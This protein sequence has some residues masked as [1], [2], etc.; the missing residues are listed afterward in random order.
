MK[1]H[2]RTRL[3]ARLRH[4]QPDPPDILK[5]KSMQCAILGLL[6]GTFQGR[7]RGHPAVQLQSLTVPS[8]MLSSRSGSVCRAHF[9][10]AT[11][12]RPEGMPA[13]PSNIERLC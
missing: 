10:N 7:C 1:Q 12:T 6:T 5:N 13:G 3:L 11:G 2:G 8:F 4:L 9:P